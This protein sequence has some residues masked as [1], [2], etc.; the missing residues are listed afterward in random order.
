M[1]CL[2]LDV[3]CDDEFVIVNR[4]EVKSN[5]GKMDPLTF[6][7]YA[8][9]FPRDLNNTRY[10]LNRACSPEFHAKVIMCLDFMHNYENN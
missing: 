10:Y 2:D 7:L 5:F 4:T 3:L 8:T 1:E 9:S 6:T